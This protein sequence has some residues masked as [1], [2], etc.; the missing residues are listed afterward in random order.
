[1][2]VVGIVIIIIQQACSAR[3]F[4]CLLGSILELVCIVVAQTTL[5]KERGQRSIR[6]H[7]IGLVEKLNGSLYISPAECL[8]PLRHQLPW[9]H[10][11]AQGH[12]SCHEQWNLFCAPSLFRK[13][14][15]RDKAITSWFSLQQQYD[16]KPKSSLCG[17]SHDGAST[18]ERLYC[19]FF[20]VTLFVLIGKKR[21]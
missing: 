11:V 6:H 3:S 5:P 21:E 7:G 17:N 16:E 8:H 20:P 13:C 18:Q 15:V 12:G 14:Y 19:P 4:S 9:R 1:M 10:A 2:R